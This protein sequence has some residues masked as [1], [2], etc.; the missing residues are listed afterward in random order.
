VVLPEYIGP[1]LLN[2][3][4]QLAGKVIGLA[5]SRPSYGRYLVTGFKTS[6]V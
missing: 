3:L 5:D 2:D 1:A 4:I 6:E